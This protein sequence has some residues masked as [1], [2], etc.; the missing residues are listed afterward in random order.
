MMES[1]ISTMLFS[2]GLGIEITLIAMLAH[3]LSELN[4]IFKR[5]NNN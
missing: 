4:M 3:V 1:R 5:M 2:L